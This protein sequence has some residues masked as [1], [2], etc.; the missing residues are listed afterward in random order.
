M[1]SS[2][3]R[4]EEIEEEAEETQ[5]EVK[6]EKSIKKF[7]SHKAEPVHQKNDQ[8]KSQAAEKKRKEFFESTVFDEDESDANS[9]K[10]DDD[11]LNVPAFFRR[12]KK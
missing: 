6:I 12:K 3:N 10:I 7:E 11:I 4:E 9:D 8:V 1:N 5:V 2:K